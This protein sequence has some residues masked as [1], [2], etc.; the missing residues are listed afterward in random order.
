MEKSKV[1][2]HFIGSKNIYFDVN[3]VIF[4]GAIFKNGGYYKIADI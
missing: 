3:F 1:I 2:Q 4:S